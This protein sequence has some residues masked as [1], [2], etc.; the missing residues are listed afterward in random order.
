MLVRCNK[1][2]VIK[3][4]TVWRACANLHTTAAAHR[5][6]TRGGCG[7]S[8]SAAENPQQCSVHDNYYHRFH[9]CQHSGL[10][11][12]RTRTHARTHALCALALCVSECVSVAG[13][14]SHLSE[15]PIECACARN[16]SRRPVDAR[17]LARLI[18]RTPAPAS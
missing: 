1:V 2:V 5:R 9:T 10:T 13:C 18:S 14:A 7:G 17:S 16:C 15:L 6:A 8:E 4:V 3:G 12:T 11:R